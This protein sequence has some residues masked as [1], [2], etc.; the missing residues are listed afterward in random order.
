MTHSLIGNSITN[1]RVQPRCG[2]RQNLR[3][4]D[5]PEVNEPLLGWRGSNVGCM[6]LLAA[7]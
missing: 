3:G 1:G 4:Q 2:C 7:F 5:S 6:P